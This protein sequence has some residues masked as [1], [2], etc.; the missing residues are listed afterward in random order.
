[1]KLSKLFNYI[2][3]EWDW[4]IAYREIDNCNDSHFSLDK[5][6]PFKIIPIPKGYWAADPFLFKKNE[7]FYC[8]FELFDKKKRKAALGYKK[9]S[10]SSSSIGIMH[11]FDGHSSYPFLFESNGSI[12][13]IPETKYCKK[14]VLLRNVEWPNK[15]VDVGTLL[16]GVYAVDSTPFF[17]DNDLYLFVYEET[18]KNVNNLYIAKLDINNCL[19]SDIVLVKEYQKTDGRPGGG[20]IALP[21]G[22]IRVV[23][24]ARQRYGEKLEFLKFAFK[25]G[26]YTEEIVDELLP[27]QVV[28]NQK[29]Q[30]VGVHTFNT[31]DK[32]QIID[33]LTK[34]KFSLTRPFR[35]LFSKMGIFGYGCYD[36]K[37]KKAFDK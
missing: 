3:L 7:E 24:P 12:Y 10:D 8:F 31:C 2:F 18:E 4:L 35:Y 13:A 28:L 11:E 26:K 32:Y 19:L 34:G 33:V 15:W 30:L 5:S 21:D 29:N 27:S 9:L 14:I 37:R 36:Q 22:M 1:M 20:V 25:D 16:D 6:I 17:I 23:Q